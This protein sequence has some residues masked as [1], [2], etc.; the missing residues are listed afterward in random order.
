MDAD[1]TR[2]EPTILAELGE[3]RRHLHDVPPHHGG[4]AREALTGRQRDLERELAAV[5]ARTAKDRLV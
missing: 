4:G 5:R 1:H 2:S 3:V